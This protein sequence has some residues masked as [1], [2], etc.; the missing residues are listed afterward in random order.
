MKLT[1]V[2]GFD[3]LAR[4][5]ETGAVIISTQVNK[6]NTISRDLGDVD[7]L[8]SGDSN[9]VDAI[10]DIK[11]TS[12]INSLIDGFSDSSTIG[13]GTLAA[14]NTCPNR[15]NLAFGINALQQNTIG[16]CNVAVGYGAL[17]YN[18]SGDGNVAVGHVSQHFTTR[19]LH[20]V[21][22]GDRSLQCNECGFMNVAVGHRALN[23]ANTEYNTAIG[24][25]NMCQLT[26]GQCNTNIGTLGMYTS[27]TA[28]RN[29]GVGVDNLCDLTAGCC[30]VAVGTR[31]GCGL[32]NGC[33]NIMIG[34]EVNVTTLASCNE[35][36]IGNTNNNRL[37]IPGLGLD[38]TNG[39]NLD[40]LSWNGSSNCF[41]F[42]STGCTAYSS[43]SAG[44]AGVPPNNV[45][46]A[47]DRIA[48][49]LAA[50]GQNP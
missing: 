45:K 16:Y 21:S 23:C 29:V 27:L 25:D 35:I 26:T 28:E 2:E 44:W 3:N 48:T 20:N 32:V 1:K 6:I 39:S 50:L 49:A 33:N 40:V 42:V 36:V 18:D 10:N 14:T 11:C 19:G 12:S 13:V 5:H 47:L 8:I 17:Q 46:D 43:G 24:G 37:R 34:Y 31:A 7:R 9:V 41:Q 38:T 30:N 15:K 22:V 4:D